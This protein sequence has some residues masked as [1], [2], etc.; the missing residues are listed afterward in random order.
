MA[1]KSHFLDTSGENDPVWIHTEPYSK[2]PQFQKLTDNL[3]TDACVIGSGIAG[4]STSY[5]LVSRGVNV[6]ML[7][8]R[9]I[10]SGESGRTSGHL[11]SSIDSGF[12]ELV[13]KRGK[14]GARLAVESHTWAINRVGEISK[15]LGIDCEYRQLPGYDISQYEKGQDGHEDDVKD[16]KEEAK[17]MNE[18]GIKASYQDNFAVKGWDGK[19]DQR[20]A[21]TYLG[22]ATFHPTKYILGVL[23]WL[24]QQ[25]NFQCYTRTRVMSVE[26]KGLLNKEVKITTEAGHTVTC[27]NAVEA[28]CVPLQ[29][30]SVVAEMKFY[31]TYCIAVRVPKGSVE[32]CLLYDSMDPY[33]Y[34]R[35]T[36]CDE[37]DDYLIIGGNDHKVGQ[38]NDAGGRYSELESWVRARFTQAGSVDYRWSGQIFEPVD[39]TAFIGANQG[40]SHVYICT[41]D[42]GNGLTHGVLAGKLLADEIMGFKNPWSKLYNP[43]RIPPLSQIPGMVAHD[44]QINA[45]YKRF[46][47]SDIR[48]IEDLAPG[49]GGVLNP[50]TQTPVAVYKDDGGKVHRFSAL[51]PHMKGVVC[52]NR[53]EKSWDCP[54]HGSRFGKDG[55]GI[56]GPAKGNLSPA[57]EAGEA[58]LKQSSAA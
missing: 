11:S 1:S 15:Q 12:T 18:L 14:D 7:E 46:L 39:Y 50:T 31:R 33:H 16:F 22:Q 3:T 6:A 52:W 32:D 40:Q 23:K 25:P 10:L 28:T 58:L 27:A 48:D 42:F 54:V 4:V 43:S 21:I 57:D 30:L 24:T 35:F 20:D 45:Q 49:T 51:C 38:E 17:V 37:N 53:D 47:Q 2:R 44:A 13:S 5:E 29:K 55:V 34:V 36:A 41:G 8:A 26:E 9:D 56:M 19:V